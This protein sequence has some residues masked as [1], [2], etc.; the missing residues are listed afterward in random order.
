V[1]VSSIIYVAFAGI[2]G[3]ARRWYD[4][5]DESQRALDLDPSVFPASWVMGWTSLHAGECSRATKMFEEGVKSSGGAAL[6]LFGLAISFAAAGEPDAARKVLLQLEKMSSHIY[7]MPYWIAAVYAVLSE[8]DLA[9]RW[10][11]H[12]YEE[13]SA[14]IVFLKVYPW[15][16]SLRSDSRFD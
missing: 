7:V 1:P 15:P 13:H 14:W 10:F 4:A 9:F 11:E 16:H 12:A 6:F 8:N 3:F 5:M 2:L